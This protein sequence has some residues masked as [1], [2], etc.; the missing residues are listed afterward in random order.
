MRTR[1]APMSDAYWHNAGLNPAT[2]KHEAKEFVVLCSKTAKTPAMKRE[3]TVCPT[4]TTIERKRSPCANAF[5]WG[6]GERCVALRGS[7]TVERSEST[8]A[9]ITFNEGGWK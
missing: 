3:R 9:P 1:S 6:S 5:K 8:N 4:A 2:T 7:R